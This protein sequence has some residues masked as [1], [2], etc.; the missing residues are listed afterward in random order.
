MP[1]GTPR[2]RSTVARSRATSLFPNYR[3]YWKEAG[4]REVMLEIE[5]AL[6]AGERDKLPELMPDQWIDDC[7]LS[8][9]A[10]QVR[11]GLEAW[12]ATGVTPDR[13][14]VLHDGRP[15]EGDPAALR[16][17]RLTR[18]AAAVRRHSVTTTQE[19]DPGTSDA[20]SAGDLFSRRSASMP[21]P[22]ASRAPN[23]KRRLRVAW[24]VVTAPRA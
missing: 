5:R 7:T 23:R 21:R 20:G 4:Y 17:L 11:D 13:G 2:A 3:N 16:P 1:T 22:R 10:D 12:H 14:H 15:A 6:E 9:S 24:C 18:R 8:G 19:S